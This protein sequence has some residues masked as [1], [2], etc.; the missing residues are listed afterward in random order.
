MSVGIV[1]F[2][3][4]VPQ[5]RIKVSDIAAVWEKDGKDIIKSLGVEEKAVAEKW[6]GLASKITRDS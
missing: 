1:A 6:I 3:S 5:G 2:G 4:Y